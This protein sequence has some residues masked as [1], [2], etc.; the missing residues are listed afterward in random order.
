MLTTDWKPL[1]HS[2]LMLSAGVSVAM[3]HFSATCRARYA[4]SGDVCCT[5]PMHTLSTAEGLT[6]AAERAAAVA[7]T[8]RS[9]AVRP[10]SLP[11]NA[12]NGVRFAPTMNKRCCMWLAWR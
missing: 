1:P 11:P 9:V 4:A 10:F 8:A 12:P 7:L 3:S 5:F 6:F 2:R